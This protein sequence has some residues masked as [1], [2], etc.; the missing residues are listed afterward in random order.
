VEEKKPKYVVRPPNTLK[1]AF[2]ENLEARQA[3]EAAEAAA[4]VSGNIRKYGSEYI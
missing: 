1:S 3:S 2:L 4:K